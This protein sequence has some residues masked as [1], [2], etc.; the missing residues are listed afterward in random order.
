MLHIS[1]HN[2]ASAEL[3]IISDRQK[4]LL[5]V[6]HNIFPNKVHA[7]CANHL[8][9]NVKQK[10]GKAVELYF[11]GCVYSNTQ[12]WYEPFHLNCEYTPFLLLNSSFNCCLLFVRVGLIDIWRA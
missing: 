2:I 8:R 7:H 4:G 10:F 11:L 1:I 5:I 12:R 6:A 9:A 3:L